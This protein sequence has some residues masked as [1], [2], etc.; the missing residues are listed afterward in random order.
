MSLS[1]AFPWEDIIAWILCHNRS[2]FAPGFSSFPCWDGHPVFILISYG[3]RFKRRVCHLCLSF[4]IKDQIMCFNLLHLV[5]VYQLGQVNVNQVDKHWNSFPFFYYFSKVFLYH[6][7]SRPW[8]LSVFAAWLKRDKWAVNCCTH[9]TL[10]WILVDY[11]IFSWITTVVQG[12]VV[13]QK[14][15]K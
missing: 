1:F 13:S 2:S 5:L 3:F 10:K 9:N 11:I 15:D 7:E 12:F 8:S 6:L 14:R 4:R